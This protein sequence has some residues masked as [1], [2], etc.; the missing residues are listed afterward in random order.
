M[1]CFVGICDIASGDVSFAVH[2]IVNGRIIGIEDG[3]APSL[4]EIQSDGYGFEAFVTDADF[5]DGA[6]VDSPELRQYLSDILKRRFEF[7]NER[8]VSR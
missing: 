3:Y 2:P 7:L 1:N 8:T 6:V 5:E 4:K